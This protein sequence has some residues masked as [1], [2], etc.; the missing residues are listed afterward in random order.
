M[1]Y[2]YNQFGVGRHFRRRPSLRREKSCSASIM[3]GKTAE[4]THDFAVVE[5]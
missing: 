3:L 4:I 2:K 1:L 5:G